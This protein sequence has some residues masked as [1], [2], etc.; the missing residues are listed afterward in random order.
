MFGIIFP[1]R[2]F[3]PHR[4]YH[5]DLFVKTS[6]PFIL[7]GLF[8]CTILWVIVSP[9]KAQ[10]SAFSI[11]K[12]APSEVKAG[13]PITY[14]IRVLNTSSL[15]I[16]VDISDPIPEN[17]TIFNPGDGTFAN[18]SIRWSGLSVPPVDSVE[19]SFIAVVT[20]AGNVTNSDYTATSGKTIVSGTPV[21][22]VIKPNI[23][24]IISVNSIPN[25][26]VV[27]ESSNL[28]ILV[29]D[30][31]GNPVEDGTIVSL[32]FDKGTINGQSPGTT[33]NDTT[34]DGQIVQILSAGTVAGTINLTATADSVQGLGSVIVNAGLP[35][36]LVVAASPDSV[37]TVEGQFATITATV[38]DQYG[39]LVTQTPVTF[40]TSLGTLNNIGSTVVVNTNN[41]QSTTTL[42]GTVAGT[43][44]LTATVGSLVNS[45]Q[46]VYLAPGPPTQIQ[47]AANPKAIVAN[48]VNTSTLTLLI[49]DENLNL[50][51]TPTP[52]TI[53]TSAGI[54]SGGGN[55][56]TNIPTNGR[57]QVTL[58]AIT[59]TSLANVQAFAA[60]LS[61]D[62]G[63]NFVPGPPAKVSLDANPTILFA[64]GL[65]TTNLTATVRDAYDNLVSTPAEVAFAAHEGTLLDPATDTTTD[66]VA[67]NT[68]RS[69]T[70][71][72]NVPITVT[73]VGLASPATE[74]IE[75][76]AGPP[77]NVDLIF[78]P[79]SPV[80]VGTSV[81]LVLT[82]RDSVGHILPNIPITL[83][84]SLGSITSSSTGV[85][86]DYGQIQRT[87]FST[88]AGTDVIDVSSYNG[89][90]TIANNSITFLPDKAV[91]ATLSVAPTEIVANGVSTSQVTALL[92]D[93]YGNPVSGVAP[94][95]LTTLGSLSGNAPT[96]ATGITTRVLQ[97]STTRGAAIITISGLTTVTN[98]TVDFITGPP[99][100]V[101][102]V[103][104]PTT[105]QAGQNVTVAITV[106]DSVGHPISEQ[107]LSVTT[108]LGVVSNCSST[109]AL[110]E[111]TCTLKSTQSGQPNIYVAG[112]LATGDTISI[113]PGDLHHIHVTPYGTTGS[114]VNISAGSP[115][116]FSAVGHD[117][118]HNEITGLS[119]VWSKD[120]FGGNGT[121]NS[122][123]GQFTGTTAGLVRIK[124]SS[125][126][127]A[128]VSY[129]EVG[130]GTP[131]VATITAT[132]LSVPANG[133][134][135]S[136]LS[137][138]VTDAF[139][140]PV[141]Y[142]VPLTVISSIGTIQG[143]AV[144]DSGSTASRT[145]QSTQAGTAMISITNLITLTGD[146]A[147]TFTPGTPAKAVVSASPTSLPANGT[148]QSILTISLLDI[149]NNPVG[150]GYNAT[151]QTSLGKLSGSGSTNVEGTLIRTLT[152]PLEIGTAIF[153]IKYL[154]LPLTVLGDKVNFEVGPLDYVAVTPT[155]MLSLPAG[156]ST[157]F[158]AQGYDVDNAPI[159]S[160]INYSWDL[161][162]GAGCGQIDTVFGQQTSFTGT[163]AGTGVQLV[164]SA[165]EEGAF[166]DNT[167][168]I[169]VIPGFPA[170][171]D[172]TVTPDS[173][174]VDTTNPVTLTFRDLVDD[175]N[176]ES[177]DGTVITMNV[178]SQ[179][180]ARI[181]TTVVSGGQAQGIISPTTQAG[182]YA[183][184]AFSNDGE[185]ALSGNNV[186]TF[187]PGVPAA[188]ELITGTPSQIIANGIST[189]TLALQ[190]RDI[191]GNKVAG[192]AT[193]IV[194]ST[195]GTILSNDT[196]TDVNGIVTRTLK[197]G[198]DLGDAKISVNGFVASGPSVTLVPGPPF[199][200]TITVVTSTLIAGGD[201]TPIVYDV[202]DAWG[203]SV[204]DS[205]IITPTLTPIYGTFIGDAKTT[206]GLV[207]QT[208]IPGP[209][210]GE[211]IIGSQGISAT[212]DTLVTINPA[213]AAIA[214]V[215]ANPISL[216]VGNTTTLVITITDEFGNIVPPTS[217][218]L[219]TTAGTLDS[220]S[221]TINKTT[222]NSTGVISADLSSTTAGTQTLTFESVAGLLTTDPASD[223]VIFLPDTPVTVTLDPSE[224]L[225]IAAGSPLAVTVS[226]R[227]SY[228]NPVDPWMPVNYN[229]QQSAPSGSPGYGT[230]TSLDPHTRSIRFM[231]MQVGTN[232][233]WTIGGVTTSTLLSVSVV[234]GPPAAANIAIN[235]TRVPADG[236][237]TYAI[238]L[239]KIVDSFNN[240]IPDGTPLTF[241]V[242]SYPP[243]I[244]RGTIS[245]G[246]VTGILSSSTQAGIHSIAVEG[247]NRS[248]TLSGT[249]SVTFTPGTPSLAIVGAVPDILPGDGESTSSII[250]TIY[251]KY[252]NLVADATPVTVTTSLGTLSGNGNTVD[253]HVIRSLQSPVDLGT[254]TFT[255]EGPNGLLSVLGDTVE[256][257]P[258]MPKYAS[259]TA[260]PSQVQ[261]DGI[262]TS[263][264][265]VTIKDN[266]GFTVDTSKTAVLTVERGTVPPDNI[267]A[268]TGIF[269][270]T[271]TADTS[272]GSA[273]LKVT[274]DD[275][276]LI[277]TGD[278]LELIPGLAE[279]ATISANPSTIEAGSDQESIL[280]IDLVD[281]WGHPVTN[282][283]TATITP[284][285][286]SISLNIGTTVSGTITRTLTP[287]S[288]VGTVHFTVNADG[289]N[290]NVSGDTVEITSGSLDH[291]DIFPS[292]P[293]QVM[294]GSTVT[295]NAVGYDIVKNETGTGVFNW[296]KWPGSGN[297][298]LSSSGIF[299]G[300][301]AGNI[302]IQA[303]QEGVFSPI[304]TITVIPNSPITAVVSAKPI[305]VA[306]GGEA[307]ELT[308]TA[309]D[310]YDNLV[311]DGT[312]L[313]VVTNL[314]TL[315]GS[316]GTK[317]GVLTRTLVSDSYYGVVDVFINGW[318]ASGDKPV[319]MPR[320]QVTASSTNL[321]ADGRSQSVLT[322]LVL[323]SQG[324]PLPDGS[325]PLITTSLGTISGTGSTVNGIITRTLTSSVTPGIAQI[326]VNGTLAKGQV[327]F[328]LGPASVAYIKAD[329]PYLMA[330]GLSKTKFTI[331]VQDAY[332]HV[333]T[334]A[335]PLAV[336]V[337]D[338]TISGIQ[339]TSNGVTTRILKSSKQGG[340]GLISVSGLSVA[341]DWKIHY[342]SDSLNGGGFE[343][344]NLD[345]WTIGSVVT[346]TGTSLVYSA[347]VV[348]QDTIGS[349]KVTPFADNRMIR[350]GATT[351]D[352][353]KHEVSEV[354]LSQPVYVQPDGMTQ[355]TFMYRLLSYDVSVGSAEYGFQEWDP[356][357]V[358]LNGHE[359]LQDGYPW[360]AEWQTWHGPPLPSS[361]Q[362]M[363]WKQ[364]IL[365]LTPYAGQVVTLEFRTPNR[366]AAID[367]TWVYIDNINLAYQEA[368]ETYHTFLPNIMK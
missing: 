234:T 359:V 185:I 131:K 336:T 187:T 198:L 68:L 175:Y 154:G 126:G 72:G 87:L 167:T 365:D 123:N 323:D 61:T 253:G 89:N 48:G 315:V 223:S 303:S 111:L 230:L 56:Y 39:N 60:G 236:L 245:N 2:D 134:D 243:V 255:V 162:C 333:I 106:T 309:R 296:K 41:G 85:S 37:R 265:T 34:S 321:P 54:L 353:S 250:V 141:G 191:F 208:L 287:S 339:P 240:P 179:P 307:I 304:K 13:E 140:N 259:I 52:V 332:G 311:A 31:Y 99:A 231:P 36:S 367:N 94:N 173:I 138:Y 200:T 192:G 294:A 42:A 27:N 320:A 188:A 128:G 121:I 242:Q 116:V 328:N 199:S 220:S 232:Q 44:T 182:T 264:I 17:M 38:T 130:V 177:T 308:I 363:G 316:G 289:S 105:V 345:N 47:L 194:T 66:G 43:A 163:I 118:Y 82:V 51:D 156:Q 16:K 280:T 360:T 15:E 143:S 314:G 74:N 247:A 161:I 351:S 119:F 366:Q 219:T 172:I 14:T 279:L 153:N 120:N 197:A 23:P 155:G 75:F 96:D 104:S 146:T 176:N 50:I 63:I 171:A 103:A 222:I 263:L 258:G 174:P 256:F 35:A 183:I 330:D 139:G 5:L 295:F 325:W 49:R 18:N 244:S 169:I 260:T 221:S 204:V 102:L 26:I 127:K 59:K 348:G 356:F 90:L 271:F 211:T 97:S 125:G 170:S 186:V 262:S 147:I 282:G 293:I 29:T 319:I 206:D 368:A 88:I 297:G 228:G 261:A 275:I 349:I 229:W 64:D 257:V 337:S 148:D 202:R 300:I 248:L 58:T 164:V 233:L 235:P 124:A 286:G 160:G 80:T 114:P 78:S 318:E 288:I 281:A 241:T 109:N 86:D 193:P 115:F 338:G 136:T 180:V 301:T 40:T 122:N 302:G 181:I 361:P 132:P 251:D 334:N 249:T 21:T 364:S 205:T 346:P 101:I 335:G 144:T 112:I 298:T 189:K 152:A 159:P 12:L 238:T 95:F 93:R 145:I 252:F 344:G 157:Q 113:V 30:I 70:V 291:I 354:W 310:A 210:A 190:L 331:T 324:D 212:G 224:P 327:S 306:V 347:T 92:T 239:T 342:V 273:G 292:T 24:G 266:Y 272:V 341:G 100:S 362:D 352:N 207:T 178:Q 98:T 142:G 137:I 83:S 25:S 81:D 340:V 53:T 329:T 276:P 46:H 4:Y 9:I 217:I 213:A 218:T 71:L 283:T 278:M 209:T 284:S 107:N 317:N 11:I 357:E 277:N 184:T 215:V 150:S 246:M 65:S 69:S 158:I 108:S 269:T 117:V 313:N 10:S 57:V 19:V 268:S 274:Y 79:T 227:D 91:Q 196:S 350:L 226:S 299:T 133:T 135:I 67:F 129:V 290:L 151:I 62:T 165:D 168:N 358:Y 343:T 33:I 225:T 110:G 28:T 8:L 6:M 254:A 73:V 203:H 55:T 270:T 355:V 77:S 76:I 285:L 322:I 7:V 84:N 214:H 201:G 305:T 149:F 3:P 312:M 20:Q 237:S 45:S 166:Y 195:L 326:Y 1:A 267:T 216:T 22:T 32:D